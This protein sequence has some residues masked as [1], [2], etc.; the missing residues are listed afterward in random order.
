MKYIS[1]KVLKGKVADRKP[2][3]TAVTRVA[4]K[5]VKYVLMQDHFSPSRYKTS[6]P[7]SA[8]V[9]F[10]SV[11]TAFVLVV[12]FFVTPV[13]D[14]YAAEVVSDEPVSEVASVQ[15]IPEETIEEAEVTEE[16]VPETIEE[17]AATSEYTEV[18]DETVILPEAEDVVPP[19]DENSQ[20][21]PTDEES[22]TG[23]I[24][25]EEVVSE[26]GTT[27][28]SVS[29]TTNEVPLVP[30]P[31][32][33][34]TGTTT[35]STTQEVVATTTVPEVTE[36]L[37]EVAASTTEP[38]VIEH[39]AT[40]S[41][42][43]V[44][45]HTTD[46]NLYSFGSTE[47]IPVGDGAYHCIKR[48]VS[49]QGG[50]DAEAFKDVYSAPD[51][52]GDMEIYHVVNG[53]PEQLTSNTD[54][55]GAPVYD[56]VT[57]DIVWHVLKDDR[58]QIMQFSA[59]T[60]IISQL[61][62]ESYNS[63]QPSIYDGVIVWQAWKG[64]N[65]EIIEKDDDEITEL[66]TNSTQD[67]NPSIQVEYVSWQADENGEWK[68]KIYNRN[69]KHI[70][71]VSGIDGGKIEN[72]RIVLVFD[73]TK[74]NGDVETVG[75]DPAKG[76]AVS[77]VS[78]PAPLPK[79][80][81]EPENQKEEKAF[82]QPTVAPKLETKATTTPEV[83]GDDPNQ[84]V[85]STTPLASLSSAT[86]TQPVEVASTTDPII[87]PP[88]IEPAEVV[89]PEIIDTAMATST[90]EIIA[91]PDTSHIAEIVIPP[92]ESATTTASE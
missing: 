49:S 15:A 73:N 70:E 36:E 75:F 67:I 40:T 43:I 79:K 13:A 30:V 78:T 32:G 65:W 76:E 24:A 87:E 8:F 16:A 33:D 48:D 1:R 83:G 82:V 59:E 14:A 20:V 52:D 26:T 45:T 21:E 39:I 58:Y 54:D 91:V 19:L 44:E 23:E 34:G 85:G 53:V 7:K 61:T 69:T 3:R 88:V 60:G 62:R 81:P 2:K 29:T 57:G 92:Y 46:A 41:D 55:D 5:S 25:D 84:G 17:E 10:L 86:S 77:L 31:S 90:Q 12:S 11:A 37:V 72:P 27:T 80:V 18:T 74:E 35:A 56:S 89:L 68:V 50:D 4:K 22:A 6:E 28:E 9:R 47:C 51:K 63:M 42:E 71:T 38:E 64:N 66:T